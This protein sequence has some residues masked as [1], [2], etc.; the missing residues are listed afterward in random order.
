MRAPTRSELLLAVI[1][2]AAFGLWRSGA[3][4]V[5]AKEA[6]LD[7]VQA[8]SVELQ[9]EL[10]RSQEETQVLR[11]EKAD[12][13]Q[14]AADSLALLND[15]IADAEHRAETLATQ[16]RQAFEEILETVPDS[17]PELRTLIERRERTHETE[18]AVLNEVIVGERSVSGVLRQQLRSANSLIRGQDIELEAG[19]AFRLSLENEIEILEDLRSPGLSTLEAVALSSGAYVITTELL[20]GSTLEGLIAVGATFVVLEGGSWL[21]GWIF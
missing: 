6:E 7:L 8:A 2:L 14:A 13:D 16:G 4:S 11:R 9:A 1:A 12:A 18:V 15:V 20:G 5:A 21:L 17:L 10:G 3:A 19:S